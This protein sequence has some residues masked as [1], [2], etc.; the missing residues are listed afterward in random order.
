FGVRDVTDDYQAMYRAVIDALEQR[1]DASGTWRRLPPVEVSPDSAPCREVVLRGD[2][3]D[4]EQYAWLKN[5]PADGGR[6]INITSVITSDP[7]FGTNVGT[8]RCQVRDKRRISV[9]PEPG[10][11]GWRILQGMKKRGDKVAK[12]AI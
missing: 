9:N 7:E 5:N 10:Q 11:H 1:L 12:V 2:D 8:Y 4:I 3:I 6:Y